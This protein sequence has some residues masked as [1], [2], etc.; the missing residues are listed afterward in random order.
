[1]NR[2]VVSDAGTDEHNLAFDIPDA[3]LERA[4]SAERQAFT[5]VYCANS[6]YYC[7]WPQERTG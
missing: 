7:E 1:M 6:W 3:A 5:W 4:A 2:E